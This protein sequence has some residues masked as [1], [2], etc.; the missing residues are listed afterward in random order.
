MSL[1]KQL[2][3]H[4][5]TI[6][7]VFG[8]RVAA[9][10]S[11]SSQKTEH[12]TSVL[13]KYLDNDENGIIDNPAVGKE[14]KKR[15][16]TIVMFG[17]QEEFERKEQ[18]LEK[19][20]DDQ[21][22]FFFYDLFANET[23]PQGSSISEGFDASLEEI[24]HLVTE[25]GYAFAY[26][27]AFSMEGFR[28]N[29]KKSELQDAMDIAR[30]GFFKTTPKQYPNKAWYSYN[31]RTCDYQCQSNEYIYWGLTSLLG[32][33]NYEG[34]ENQIADEWKLNTPSK[35]KSTDR[36]LYSLLTN[37]KYN[38]PTQLP[39]GN[40]QA[41]SDVITNSSSNSSSS[42]S[43][44]TPKKYRRKFAQKINL[45]DPDNSIASINTGSFDLDIDSDIA[46]AKNTRDAKKKLS[47]TSASFIYEANSGGLCFNENSALKGFGDGG[48][49]AI[50]NGSPELNSSNFELI[51]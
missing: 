20:A 48:L 45:F 17:S 29:G 44:S 11:V 40:Y 32:G 4:F 12:A 3:A 28:E 1:D 41:D 25:A 33:Q 34:R 15:N 21:K 22:D 18:V 50:F 2:K 13:S 7:N 37:P 19:I 39:D 5:K 9:S 8:V 46:F 38:F 16:A 27:K 10:N 31:D 23:H 51:N 42:F 35:F 49:I 47:K 26:P 14:L 24:L 43:I 36:A 6:N 30:G